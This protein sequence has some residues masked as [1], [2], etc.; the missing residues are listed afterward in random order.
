MDIS[1]IFEDENLRYYIHGTGRHGDDPDNLITT[2][3]F[4]NGL[5]LDVGGT[6][7]LKPSKNIGSITKP[8]GFGSA[9]LY[10]IAAYDILNYNNHFESR[11]TI[12]IGLPKKYVFVNCS[13]C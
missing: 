10:K 8:V 5:L 2:S 4:R 7:T 6:G 1:K 3:I 9:T 12:I 13:S 11:R